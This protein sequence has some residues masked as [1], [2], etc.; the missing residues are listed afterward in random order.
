MQQRRVHEVG[1]AS[2]VLPASVLANLREQEHAIIQ[3]IHAIY[4][5]LEAIA[6]PCASD[7]AGHPW[8]KERRVAGRSHAI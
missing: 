5:C 7:C 4:S 2:R 3:S 6:V 1:L 8:W